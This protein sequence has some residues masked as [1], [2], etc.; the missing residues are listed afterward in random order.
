[1]VHRI[2]YMTL[3]KV[4]SGQFFCKQTKSQFLLFYQIFLNKWKHVIDHSELHVF[5]FSVLRKLR[6]ERYV[7]KVLNV[8]K[9]Y[10]FLCKKEEVDIN[11]DWYVLTLLQAVWSNFTICF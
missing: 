5:I 9:M 2:L 11:N 4:L 3:Q 1:M 10:L 6:L 7:I 8:Y